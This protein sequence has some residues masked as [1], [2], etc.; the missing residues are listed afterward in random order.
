[1][2]GRGGYKGG[3]RGGGCRIY[4]GNLPE[5]IREREI[6]DLLDKYGRIRDLTLK[7]GRGFAFAEFDDARDAED[8]VYGLHGY[9]FGGFR[10]RV[11]F[12]HGGGSRRDDDRGGRGG[13]GGG[14][15]GGGG[16]GGG[17]RGDFR[18][19]VTNIPRTG[20]WQDLKDFCRDGGFGNVLYADVRDGE[21]V[22]EFSNRDEVSI[23]EQLH[24]LWTQATYTMDTAI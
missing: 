22:V 17:R 23:M 1:M 11:E 14:R 24:I 13:G 10:L 5:D 7:A 12:P 20:S 9:T 8:A 18:V 16:G 21:G 6:E 2:S 4:I 15:G 19:T 3:D